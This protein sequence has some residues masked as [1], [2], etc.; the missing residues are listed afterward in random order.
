M[1]RLSGSL[2]RLWQAGGVGTVLALRSVSV[3]LE[4][5]ATT[6]A[7]AGGCAAVS[8]TGRVAHHRDLELLVLDDDS[9]IC[10][11]CYEEIELPEW[12]GNSVFGHT[13]HGVCWRCGARK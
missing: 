13:E 2:T 9:V 11:P 6:V 8:E 5:G 4:R 7:I 3:G 1:T 12:P 10:A